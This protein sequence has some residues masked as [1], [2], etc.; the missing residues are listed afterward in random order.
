MAMN[1]NRPAWLS[2]VI[3]TGMALTFVC[4]VALQFV[5]DETASLWLV[6]FAIFGIVLSMAP[7]WSQKTGLWHRTFDRSSGEGDW[8]Y[9]LDASDRDQTADDTDAN[10]AKDD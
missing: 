3:Y 10:D 7:F 1:D 4:I 6:G 8:M 5:Q 2:P 9:D